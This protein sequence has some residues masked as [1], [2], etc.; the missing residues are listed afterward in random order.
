[1]AELEAEVHRLR[2]IDADTRVRELEAKLAAHAA[3]IKRLR[4]ELA[5]Y[6]RQGASPSPD[7]KQA[8]IEKTEPLAEQGVVTIEA[9]TEHIAALTKQL[10]TKQLTAARTQIRNQRNTID[11]LGNKRVLLL[12]KGLRKRILAYLHPDLRVSD[13][14]AALKRMGKTFQEFSG[15]K[16]VENE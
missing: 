4:D 10:L 3:E 1:M 15:L 16:F 7:S 13:S 14:A 2:T 5:H 11:R 8:A 6:A 12:P 9:L